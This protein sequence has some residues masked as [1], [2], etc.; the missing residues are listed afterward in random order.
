[1][2]PPSVVVWTPQSVESRWVRGEAREGA[3]RGI[4]VPVRFE[5][6]SLPIDVR[7][8]PYD[9]PR[10]LGDRRRQSAGPGVLRALEAVIAAPA[11]G[12]SQDRE[13]RSAPP[14]HAGARSRARDLASLPFVNMSGDAEQEYFSDGITEDIITD[15]EQGLGTRRHLAQQC[16]RVQGQACRRAEDRARTPRQP[17]AG[18]QRTQGGGRVRITAQLVDGASNDTSGPSATTAT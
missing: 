5:K 3:E 13:P 17:R 10:R 2:P 4:L 1:M 12:E 7:A 6:A 11:R 18:G 9:G 8:F 14:R 15:L 16:L